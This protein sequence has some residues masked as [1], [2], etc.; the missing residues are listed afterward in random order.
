MESMS[1]RPGLAQRAEFASRGWCMAPGLFTDTEVA[2]YRE[3]FMHMHAN[4]PENGSREKLDPSSSDPLARFPRIGMMHRWDRITMEWLVD[5]RLAVWLRAI[6]GR[7]PF[8]VQTMIYYKPPGARGQALHQDQYYLQVD[9]GTCV[10]AWLALDDCDEENGCLR[11][12]PGTH[13]IPVLCPVEADASQSFTDVTVPLPEGMDP[14]D[15]PM[16][17]GDVLFFNGQ[18]VHGSLPNRTGDRFRRALIAHYIQGEAAQVA[19]YYHPVLKMNGDTVDLAYRTEGGP[20]GAWVA[21]DPPEV[22][23]SDQLIPYTA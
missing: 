17:A 20:C 7:D 1:H 2:F 23:I 10:A 16:Q 21:A 22:R 8:A 9:P 18:L 12:V 19:R 5:E 6:L 14:R 3:H 11:I 4:R 15:V 13:D